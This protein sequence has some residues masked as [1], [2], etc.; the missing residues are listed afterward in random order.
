MVYQWKNISL[1]EEK[2]EL[3]GFCETQNKRTLLIESTQTKENP[4]I[5]STEL[6]NLYKDYKTDFIMQ[7]LIV[8]NGN[9][10]LGA[11]RG[12]GKTRFGISLGMCLVYEIK[13]FLGYNINNFGNVYY[14][15]FEIREPEFKLMLEPIENYFSELTTKKHAFKVI[16]FLSYPKTNITNIFDNIKEDK[17]ILIIVDSLKAFISH[18]LP[19]IKE[20]EI[21]NTN[22]LKLYDLFNKL[23]DHGGTNLILNHTNKGTKKEKS[24][25]DLMFGVSSIT[26]FAD[27]TFLLRKTNDPNKRLIIPDKCRFSSEVE[28]CTNLVEI[29]SDNEHLWF[30]LIEEDVYESDFLYNG[31][32][33]KEEKEAEKNRIICEYKKNPE[34]TP[35]QIAKDLLPD[36][37]NFDS[38]KILVY[39]AVNK[40]KKQNPF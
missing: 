14:L 37:K 23:K 40:Y 15:N 17:P 31:S 28:S 12:S 18:V 8:K 7:P 6:I 10:I 33:N 16:S 25:S 35:Y 9:N 4:V 2:Q 1:N 38:Y 34:K 30:K 32:S 20:K 3:K 26:D 19:L 13:I 21:T 11:E 39:R 22:S 5:E 24:N 27:H 29:L 36:G